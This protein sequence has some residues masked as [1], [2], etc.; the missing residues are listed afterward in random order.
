MDTIY[1]LEDQVGNY[2]IGFTKHNA[3][4]RKKSGLLT[5]NSGDLIIIHE[6]KTNHNR[7]VETSL[8]NLYSHRHV[9]REFYCLDAPEVSNFM[10]TCGTIEKGLDAIKSFQNKFY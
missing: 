2:K 5:G 7:K 9:V 3:S 6:F 1:L 10:K 4:K 8:H